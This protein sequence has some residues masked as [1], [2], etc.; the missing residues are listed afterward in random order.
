MLRFL[1]RIPTKLRNMIALSGFIGMI[2]ILAVLGRHVAGEAAAQLP[3]GSPAREKLESFRTLALWLPLIGIP[4]TVFLQLHV[5]IKV[6]IALR[7]AARVAMAAAQGDLTT[8][9][10][11]HGRDEL[12][13][14]AAS[15]NTMTS[16]VGSTV[17]GMRETAE[18]LAH[19]A[20]ELETTS[21][22]M[23][24]AVHAT[25]DR[26]GTVDACAQHAGDD[27][28]GI[29]TST[30]QMQTAIEQ[31]GTN[32][33]AVS[34]TAAGAVTNTEQAATNVA[35]LRESSRRIGDVVA[36]ITAIA[37][38][39]HL[40]ALN[41]TIEA[42]RAGEAGRGFAIV[43]GEVKDL[44]SATATATAEITT[45][46]QGIQADTDAAVGAVADTAKM[47]QSLAAHQDSI[48][49]S[50]Q[51]QSAVTQAVAARAGQAATSSAAIDDALGQ[52]RDAAD[53]TS[54][55]SMY[56][57]TAATEL[58]VMSARLTELAS[59]FRC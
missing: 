33:T 46:I 38:Q 48:S 6:I 39:T 58:S 15:F 8:T 52:V 57:R 47:I 34:S 36:S 4:V 22:T 54:Q 30:E 10:E 1:D 43:A 50:M 2:I 42:A 56:T 16:Q 21:G 19:A 31:I 32:L 55:A 7:H 35:R 49:S 28:A 18:R 37:T 20:R 9:M 53:R 5:Q 45:Q 25:V 29:T 27:L 44:A 3:A 24:D 51:D 23:Q 11:V 59:T 12:S 14:L 17:R 26:L 13:V 40:L 41:A